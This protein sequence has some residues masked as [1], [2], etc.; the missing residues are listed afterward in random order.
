MKKLFLSILFLVFVFLFPIIALDVISLNNG[1]LHIGEITQMI[2]NDKVELLTQEGQQITIPYSDIKEIKKINS[3]DTGIPEVKSNF[4]NELVT[5]LKINDEIIYNKGG[6]LKNPTCVY[7]GITYKARSQFLFGKLEPMFYQIQMNKT[8]LPK[9]LQ[10][11]IDIINK[12]NKT[13]AMFYYG[14]IAT[15]IVGLS[16][17]KQSDEV[18][19]TILKLIPIFIGIAFEI[20]GG[21]M[22]NNQ[23]DIKKFV[24]TYN[25]TY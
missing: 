1:D 13:G 22:L 17:I 23:T 5:N 3:E 21:T 2:I 14:G 20:M 19:I 18:D 24:S 16:S 15:A 7:D 9:T 25:D 4:N 11:Q 6:F 8:E 12:K 10:N